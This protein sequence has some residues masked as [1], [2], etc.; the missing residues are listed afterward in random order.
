MPLATKNN[1]I[2]VK[3]GKLA[4]SCGCCESGCC[5]GGESLASLS[6]S[7]SI[8][9]TYNTNPSGLGFL[10][11]NCWPVP[12]GTR[13]TFATWDDVV[14]TDHIGDTGPCT[15]AFLDNGLANS[16]TNGPVGRFVYTNIAIAPVAG[17]CQLSFFTT[18]SNAG[19]VGNNRPLQIPFMTWTYTGPGTYTLTYYVWSLFRNRT[20]PNVTDFED[21]LLRES[22]NSLSAI[23]PP[24]D[25][26]VV[27]GFDNWYRTA[28][29]NVVVELV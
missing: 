23:A 24:A 19:C 28:T 26:P 8:T 11:R 16:G 9:W 27:P 25:I 13:T 17:S 29:A 6:A 15:K 18:W 12:T 7:V 2:I 3:D 5:G 1:A 14:P 10:D 21:V 22:V 20:N 4:E